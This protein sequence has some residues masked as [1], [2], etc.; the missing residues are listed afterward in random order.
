MKKGFTL[1]ELL[2][3]ISLLAAIT[4]VGFLGFNTAVSSWRTGTAMADSMQH[5]DFIMEQIEMGLRSACYPDNLKPVGEYGMQLVD[6]GEGESARDILTWTKFGTSLVGISSPVANT[7][8]RISMYVVEP[9]SSDDESLRA[10]GLVI[11]AWRMT[12]LPE[13]F[14]SEDEEFVKPKLVMPG[15]V[16]MDVYVLNPKNN[17]EQGKTPGLKEESSALDDE[18][19]D[20]ISEEDWTGDYT[21][22]LPYAVQIALYFAPESDQEDQKPVEVKRSVVIPCAPLAWRDKGAA[23]GSKQTGKSSSGGKSASG[24]KD[25][26]APG[27]DNIRPVRG[28][29]G[30]GRGAGGGRGRGAGGNVN[31]V[32]RPAGGQ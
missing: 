21:N 32:P 23:G 4:V 27:R 2:L 17:L 29:G 10:G 8:H 26:R 22:R 31:P 20:W 25:G 5:A 7:A 24:N 9:E 12:C 13:D 3:V 19:I 6:E 30:R 1:V 16:G 11:K 28:Q 18:E 14:D 15:V